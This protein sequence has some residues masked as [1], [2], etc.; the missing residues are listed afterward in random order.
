MK[1]QLIRSLLRSSEFTPALL[2][3]PSAWIGHLPFAAWVMRELRPAVFV[4][5]G[6]HWGH[7]YFTFCQAV[8]ENG[9][10]TRCHAIDTWQGDPQAGLYGEEVFRAV[11]RENIPYQSFST[12]HRCTFADAVPAFADGS[13]DLLHIDGLHTYEAVKQDFET[14]L[15]KLSSRA[16]VLFHDTQARHED[17]GVWRLWAE[18]TARYPAHLEFKH[19]S[20]LGVLAVGDQAEAEWLQPAAGFQDDLRSHF[21]GLGQRLEELHHVTRHRDHLR[22]KIGELKKSWSWRLTAPLRLIS[23]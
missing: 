4:E 12:L 17:F 16:V 20:G 10:G 3:Q 22:G 21:Q 11:C 1:D 9:L 18:L 8:A 13:I 15:P 19:A 5:L 7:S 23:R 6:T 14:W 2:P